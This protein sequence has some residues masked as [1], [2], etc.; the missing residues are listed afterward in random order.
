VFTGHAHAMLVE[1]NDIHNS[2][3]Q[4]GVYLSNSGDN[5]V[6]RRNTIHNNAANGLHLNADASQGGDGI[7]T[8]V[9]VDSNTF[10]ENGAGGPYIDSNGVPQ[11]AL[12]GGS[13]I[14]CDGVMD[15]TIINNVVYAEHASG[16]SLYR[17]DGLL[18]SAN[19]LVANN[20]VLNA[21]ADGRWCL[22]IADASTGNTSFN[23]ILL[24]YHAFRG[25]VFISADSLSGFVSDFNIV[26]DRLDPDGDGPI[27]TLTLAQ[28]RAMTG[29][30]QHSI[31]LALAQ[32]AALFRDL[33]GNDYRLSEASVARDS[34]APSLNGRAAPAA[35]RAGVLRPQGTG[36]DV[37]AYEYLVPPPC[38]ADW[39]GNGH[40]DSQDYF[41]FLQ[42]FFAGHADFNRSGATDSQDFFDFLAAFFAGC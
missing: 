4:H 5:H 21:A 15:S 33:I 7:I 30:D 38:G 9:L 32:W 16:I 23:N 22:N 42:D 25:S 6:V 8:G 28:W 12:G 37:G 24:N 19:N 20:T 14:N 29:Q 17:I 41:D 2:A 39:N 34:G 36:F 31:A 3:Q 35:D 10:Y 13:A 27:P 26:M 40:I 1:D 18:P 11:T